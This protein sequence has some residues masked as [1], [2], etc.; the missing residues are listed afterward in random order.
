MH[1]QASTQVQVEPVPSRP[2]P[3]A[4]LT[5]TRTENTDDD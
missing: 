4:P 2:L 1:R 3:V 5:T